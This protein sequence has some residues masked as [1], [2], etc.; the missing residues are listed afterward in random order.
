LGNDSFI[1]LLKSA[2]PAFV[3]YD[4]SESE[5][6]DEYGLVGSCSLYFFLPLGT[7]QSA[8]GAIV[9]CTNLQDGKD[10][11]RWRSLIIFRD[12][13]FSAES[14]GEQTERIGDICLRDVDARPPDVY[15]FPLSW[16]YEGKR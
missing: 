3:D 12:G 10:G 13:R 2:D 15:Y 7:H 9:A 8:N 14:A 5:G 16:K 6:I 11:R 1:S 4:P